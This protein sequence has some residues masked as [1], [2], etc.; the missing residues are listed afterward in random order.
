MQPWTIAIL[1]L[2]AITILVIGWFIKSYFPSYFSEKGKNL[3]TKEDV[4]R[5]TYEVEAVRALFSQSLESN[6]RYANLRVQAYVDF[7]RGTAGRARAQ[8]RRDVSKETEFSI[9]L[10]DAKAR[11]AV[12]GSQE[13]LALLGVFFEHY[14]ELGSEGGRRAFLEAIVKMRQ[15]AT[16][17]RGWDS[18]TPIS[19]M[20]FAGGQRNSVA[21]KPSEP[22]TAV[23]K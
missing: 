1:S 6:K 20:L 15:E 16:A 4:G 21:E 8:Q 18:H 17:E 9:A 23:A 2:Q 14:A 22:K 19:Q 13:V 12:Y 10:T 5:I 3:A 7:I 11:I